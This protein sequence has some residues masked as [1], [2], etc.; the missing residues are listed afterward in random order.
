MN[1]WTLVGNGTAARIFCSSGQEDFREIHT[2]TN[3]ANR[4]HEHDLQSD[5]YG[6]SMTSSS[7]QSESYEEP[8][9][10]KHE[11]DRFAATVAEYLGGA[12]GRNEYSHLYLVCSPA[13]LGTLRKHLPQP[14]LNAV[15]QEIPKNVVTHSD[16]DIRAHLPQHL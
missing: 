7:S 15:K 1:T 12:F 6:R 5:R 11:R 2:F 16:A 13:F 14:V 4:L 10:R 8:S 3:P 9:A